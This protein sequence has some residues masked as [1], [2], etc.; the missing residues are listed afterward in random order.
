MDATFRII[1]Q[2]GDYTRDEWSQFPQSGTTGDH[3][4]DGDREFLE[5]LLVLETPVNRD[6]GPEA[7]VRSKAQQTPVQV[8]RPTHLLHRL[9]FKG[10]GERRPESPWHG[11][12]EQ[13]LHSASR[14]SCAVIRSSNAMACSFFTVG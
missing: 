14:I 5:V 6:E 11:F 7:V 9:Y 3:D 8:A 2:D 1:D 4:D 13:H 12:V 10:L